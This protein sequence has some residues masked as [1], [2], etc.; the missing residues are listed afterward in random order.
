M[1]GLN[2]HPP[3]GYATV[4][5]CVNIFETRYAKKEKRMLEKLLKLACTKL[6]GYVY[7]IR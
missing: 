4:R 6:Y 2:S 1:E 5:K 3:P 7:V